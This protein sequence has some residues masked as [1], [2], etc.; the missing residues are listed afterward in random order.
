MRINCS[1]G[2]D[3]RRNGWNNNMFEIYEI[4]GDLIN[5]G[6]LSRF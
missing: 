6:N 4:D 1:I 5:T 3:L 2:A